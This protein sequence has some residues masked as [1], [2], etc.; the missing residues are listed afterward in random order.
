[1]GD[2]EVKLVQPGYDVK[3]APDLNTIFTNRTNPLKTQRDI[4]YGTKTVTIGPASSSVNTEY[5]VTDHNLGYFPVFF[6]Y[7]VSYSLNYDY[8][9]FEDNHHTGTITDTDIQRRNGPEFNVDKK[10]LYFNF[11][12]AGEA[13]D[14]LGGT[15]TFFYMVFRQRV[16]EKVSYPVEAG[17]RSE[18]IFN[19][20]QDFRIE[21]TKKG[22]DVANAE[23]DD[24]L[25]SSAYP[26]LSVTKIESPGNWGSVTHGLGYIPF[27]LTYFY[28][29]GTGRIHSASNGYGI[30][31]ITINSS[32]VSVSYNDMFPSNVVWFVILRDYI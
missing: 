32:A 7:N 3:G 16:D 14:L 30:G 22:I 4:L 18:P 5:K 9:D 27:V 31:D 11:N 17:G 15:F 1:M 26:T 13:G 28:D 6:I 10:S 20:V 12:W 24:Y 29:P 8:V 23:A 25:F 2:F 19:D 21:M